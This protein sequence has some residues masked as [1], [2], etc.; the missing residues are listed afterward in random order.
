VLVLAIPSILNLIPLSCLAAV[1]FIVGFKLA[2]PSIFVHE[3]E[4]GM[5]QFL[6]FVVTIIAILFTDLLVGIGIGMVVGM[7][8]VIKT[9]FKQAILVTERN[10]NYLVKLHKDVSFLNKAP[11]KNELAKIPVNSF[12]IINGFK[13]KFVDQDIRDVLNDFIDS[14]HD[15]NIKIEIEGFDYN[16]KENA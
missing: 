3:W 6:P 1:L 2:K 7:F 8:F 12:V 11:L 4:K 10:G 5:D 14:A 16:L 9:N 15:R 13:A